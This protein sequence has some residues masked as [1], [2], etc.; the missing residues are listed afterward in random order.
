MPVGKFHRCAARIHGHADR[1]HLR[2]SRRLRPPD[3]ILTI[4]VEV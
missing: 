3:H 1:D 2:Y 4:G